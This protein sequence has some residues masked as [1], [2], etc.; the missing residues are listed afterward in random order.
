M[1]AA[2]SFDNGLALQ[3]QRP[4]CFCHAC[5]RIIDS[6][7]LANS[8][9]FCCLYCGSTFLESVEP[10]VERAGLQGLTIDQARRFAHSTAMLRLLEHQLREELEF[11]R[12]AFEQM[13]QRASRASLQSGTCFTKV[14]QS[15]LRMVA[16]DLDL[17][18]SQPSCPI[19]SEE[20]FVGG[21]AQKLP[22]THLFHRSCIL[23]WLELKQNCPICRKEI[24][25]D[26]PELIELS[27]FSIEELIAQLRG[28]DVLEKDISSTCR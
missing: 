2:A 14:M 17:L 27:T 28:F 3:T 20:F 1:G 7:A 26:I 23:P 9:E 5:H 16:V 19:C 10:V 12:S 11:L 4:C 8:A 24:S 21:S 18:C 13:N 25:D 22:C 15:K 6:D